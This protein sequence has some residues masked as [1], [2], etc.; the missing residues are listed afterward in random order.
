MANI[1]RPLTASEFDNLME[2]KSFT[3][4]YSPSRE[5]WVSEHDY[6]SDHARATRNKVFLFKDSKVYLANGGQPG[7]YFSGESELDR[8]S[9]YLSVVSN[10]QPFQAK[11]HSSLLWNTRCEDTQGIELSSTTF[12]SVRINTL[13]QD[14]EQ[15][16]LIPRVPGVVGN[17]R[18]L[19]GTWSFNKLRHKLQDDSTSW[20][21]KQRLLSKWAIIDLY[22]G[23]YQGNTLYLYD[24]DAITRIA[25]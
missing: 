7:Y 22:F 3:L 5:F 8:K 16:E 10:Q 20:R 2:D 18:R 21:E 11:Y 14:T 23:N 24:L 1:L 17:I 13:D 25:I 9:F 12:D 6:A 4:S 19:H 15:V